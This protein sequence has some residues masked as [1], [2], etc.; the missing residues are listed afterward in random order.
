MSLM[1]RNLLAPRP[2]FN[3]EQ[4][5]KRPLIYPRGGP[6]AGKAIP[7]R[8]VTTYVGVVEDMYNLQQW[9]KRMVALGLADRPDLQLAVTAHRD[10]KG[11][12]NEICNKAKEAARASAGATTGTA[13][14]AL[15]DMI[16]R[17]EELPTLPPGPAASLEKF[18][19]AT[20]PLKTKAIELQVVFDP[21]TTIDIATAGTADRLYAIGEGPK[22]RLY[23]GDTKSGNIELGTLKIAMQLALYARSQAYDVKTGERDTIGADYHRAIVMHLPATDDPAEARCELHW[24]DIEAGWKAVLV[25]RDIWAAR[26]A[27]F[28]D[29]TEPFAPDLTPALIESLIEK[30]TT[31]EAVRALYREYREHWTAE[32]NEKAQARA[33]YC[34]H[35]PGKEAKAS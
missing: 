13:L 26:K 9:E 29:L 32:L 24:I 23:I 7:Y 25:A 21:N 8:R 17:G 2:D 10:D 16:D 1:Q 30:A 14:H 11:K 5:Y 4:R 28:K 3:R 18:R 15:T 6:E 33:Q 19:E 31:A 35:L 22:R 12:L 20:A 27:K 34:D